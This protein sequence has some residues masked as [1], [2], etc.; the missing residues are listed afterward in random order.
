MRRNPQEI[1][2]GTRPEDQRFIGFADLIDGISGQARST[3]APRSM[4]A[5]G[6]PCRSVAKFSG[7]SPGR[8]NREDAPGPKSNSPQAGWPSLA[9]D[10][11]KNRQLARSFLTREPT[12]A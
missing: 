6:Q 2:A 10:A 8:F 4:W 12:Q 5:I 9:H 3:A 1:T 7:K 11:P